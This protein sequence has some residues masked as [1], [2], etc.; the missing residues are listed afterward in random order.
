MATSSNPIDF[1]FPFEPYSIQRD[2]MKALY[3]V[4][5]DGC[6]GI[7]ES[8]TG[9]GK[10]L[11]LI[12][13]GLKW[14][15]DHQKEEEDQLRELLSNPSTHSSTNTHLVSTSPNGCSD[16]E[17]DWLKQYDEVAAR[18]DEVEKAKMFLER[19]KKQAE[20]FRD[21]RKFW[22]RSQDIH[23]SKVER[24]SIEENSTSG[25]ES[26]PYLNDDDIVVDEY[27]SDQEEK[28]YKEHDLSDDEPSADEDEG[29]K[30]FYCSRTHSQL[31][32]FVQEVRKSP[33]GNGTHVISLASR[34]NMCIN[35]KV[36]RLGSNQI[37]NDRC[38]E[39]RRQKTKGV[40]TASSE[41][42][43]T[44]KRKTSK[45]SG[46]PYYKVEALETFKDLA[47][48]EV[49]DIEQLV[50]LGREL[51]A[52]SYYGSRRAVSLA[53]LVVVPYNTL[54]HATTRRAVG[55]KLKGNVVIIDEA[56]NL[57]DTI[58]N[59][60]SV[61]I[62]GSQ[63]AKAFSQLSQYK[64]RYRDRLKAKNLL[65]IS[66]ILQVLKSFLT[67][68]KKNLP[69]G[70]TSGEFKKLYKL[71]DFLFHLGIDHLNMF[72]ILKYCESSKISRKLNG[73][74]DR[75]FDTVTADSPV[76]NQC[77]SSA[78]INAE[79]K[80]EKTDVAV[81]QQRSS[82][83]MMIE[84]FLSALTNMDDNSRMSVTLTGQ[85]TTSSFR[86]LLLNPSVHFEEIVKE[87]RAVVVAGGTMQPVSEFKDQLFGSL[88]V[89]TERIREFSC[90]HVI[91][92]SNLLAVS[93][94]KGPSG[95]QFDFTFRARDSSE[96]VNSMLL[97][98]MCCQAP[99]LVLDS[100]CRNPLWLEL[101][102]LILLLFH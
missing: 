40:A 95:V 49:R 3:D 93:L 66:Q 28:S 46:C 15:K 18:R 13:G 41:S 65:Y 78:G 42:I 16:G 60:H 59:I 9:T 81:Y 94:G 19:K 64:D 38:L 12:C 43:P 23:M 79:Y 32:Q 35:E 2:F 37:I 101:L 22:K 50:S 27:I 74:V 98:C 4:L 102:I 69:E 70:C 58:C 92:E 53:E 87:C 21:A 89:P 14:L 52:C 6:C 7:F 84:A 44:K 17:P 90:G 77:S 48:S 73:F 61:E 54:L 20:R 67:S 71:N 97:Y 88:G 80:G 1:P 25:L 51:K 96:Q 30:V 99:G 63:V 76:D 34:Q 45:S 56:H 24:S 100:K 55:I 33:Y 75:Y 10:S 36:R 72:K 68:L 91:P 26:T 57:L 82:P 31:S 86:F 11:S 39:L 8:P 62:T 5:E 85:L 83:L 29:C 47:L